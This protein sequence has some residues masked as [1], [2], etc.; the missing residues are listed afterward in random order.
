VLKEYQLRL[1]KSLF[2]I[3]IPALSNQKYDFE[4][5]PFRIDQNINPDI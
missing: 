3:F 5:P 2:L 4:N 1:N